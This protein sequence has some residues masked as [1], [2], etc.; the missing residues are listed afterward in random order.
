MW[1]CISQEE[2][3]IIAL[4]YEQC[5]IFHSEHSIVQGVLYYAP[6]T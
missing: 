5:F 3:A 4:V 2:V 1:D 6:S